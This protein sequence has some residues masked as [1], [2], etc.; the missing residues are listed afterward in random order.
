MI[1]PFPYGLGTSLLL[2]IIG[3]VGIIVAITSA[4]KI[5]KKDSRTNQPNG[6]FCSKCGSKLLEDSKFCSKCGNTQEL[7]KKDDE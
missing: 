2:V 4:N 5:I 6:K 1:L 3:I 7:P